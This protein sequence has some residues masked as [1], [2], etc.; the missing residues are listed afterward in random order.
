[1]LVVLLPFTLFLFAVVVG[2][3]SVVVGDV[4]GAAVADTVAV[5]AAVGA[6]LAAAVFAVA[7]VAL[8]SSRVF[9]SLRK[10]APRAPHPS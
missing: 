1:M 2:V 3:V 5:A 9:F 4:V 7:V 8:N 6:A 10:V